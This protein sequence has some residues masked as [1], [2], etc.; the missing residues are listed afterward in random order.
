MYV[1]IPDFNWFCNV[2]MTIIFVWQLVPTEMFMCQ[3]KEEEL[4][5]LHML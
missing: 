3:I 5:N 2:C 4:L 1:I